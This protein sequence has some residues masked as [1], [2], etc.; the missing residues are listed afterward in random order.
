MFLKNGFDPFYAV[1]VV[2]SFCNAFYIVK[3]G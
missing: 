3:V 1:G 2:G